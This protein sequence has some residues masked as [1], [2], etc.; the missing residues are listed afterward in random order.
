MLYFNLD[1]IKP[2]MTLGKDLQDSKTNM[3]LLRKGTVLSESHIS[4]LKNHG[5]NGVYIESE[6][7]K[8]IVVKDVIDEQVKK[9]TIKSLK[10]FNVDNIIENAKKIVE[11]IVSNSNI[12]FDAFDTT[13]SEDIF[14]AHSLKVAEMS[15]AIGKQLDL[16]PKNLNEL[17][18][19]AL[20]HDYGK[21]CK[22][23]IMM[24]KIK[25]YKEY[26]DVNNFDQDKYP[27][28]SYLLTLD[29]ERLSATTRNIILSHNIDMNNEAF[30]VIRNNSKISAK[31]NILGDIIHV[32]DVYDTVLRNATESK[33]YNSSQIIEYLKN[34]CNNMINMKFLDILL[35]YI[36]LYPI[37]SIVKLSDNRSAV[38][39]K[40]NKNF[41]DKPIIKTFT[42]QII[43]LTKV[44]NIVI[45]ENPNQT[46]T[47]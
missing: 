23:D 20:L 6:L 45:T 12:S 24:A 36:P 37:G 18:I 29:F 32:V 4:S 3:T 28:Y 44:L 42:G 15:I 10:E 8:D 22:N 1:S 40:N 31:H 27:L 34:K 38:V 25:K 35:E 16:T 46:K 7:F 9:D 13:D 21:L 19:A 43:D 17:A 14:Y 11:E 41:P 2:G 30:A 39:M 26:S 33:E 47:R 5:F